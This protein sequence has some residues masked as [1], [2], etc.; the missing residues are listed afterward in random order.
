M[1]LGFHEH[2]QARYGQARHPLCHV[3]ATI[4]AAELIAASTISPTGTSRECGLRA[5]SAG[6]GRSTSRALG[7][8]LTG[9]RIRL[10]HKRH[11]DTV[12]HD[13]EA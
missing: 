5:I 9:G 12:A 11:A 2:H 10:T 1:P 4:Q 8:P 7:V 13:T 3:C 6:P